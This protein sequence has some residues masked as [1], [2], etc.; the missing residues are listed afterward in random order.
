LQTISRDNDAGNTLNVT[1]AFNNGATA[2]L[3]HLVRVL[4]DL[5]AAQGTQ[6][7]ALS[8]ATLAVAAAALAAVA[9]VLV[10]VLLRR[11]GGSAGGDPVTGQRVT[12]PLHRGSAS[13]S[14]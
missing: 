2:N 9:V 11:G 8:I 10:C 1:L 12:N 7:T 6:L 14:L 5:A 3:A 13:P 4:A